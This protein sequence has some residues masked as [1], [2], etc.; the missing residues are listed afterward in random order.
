MDTSTSKQVE[1]ADFKAK[2]S[3][4]SWLYGH[5][6]G[7]FEKRDGEIT[8]VKGII[9]STQ[10]TDQAPTLSHQEFYQSSLQYA[11]LEFDHS[12]DD[13]DHLNPEKGQPNEVPIKDNGKDKYVYQT[14]LTDIILRYYTIDIIKTSGDIAHGHIKGLI[15]AK[16]CPAKK[17]NRLL[18]FLLLLLS[19][20]LLLL[21]VFKPLSP[22]QPPQP[23][24]WRRIFSPT[25]SSPSMPTADNSDESS[26]TGSKDG[27]NGHGGS[28]IGHGGPVFIPF[29]DIP[30]SLR[31]DFSVCQQSIRINADILFAF[32]SATLKPEAY[33]EI[34]QLKSFFD[35]IKRHRLQILITGHTDSY[36]DYDYNQRLSQRRA[37]EISH[38][39]I[40]ENWLEAEQIITEGRGENELIVSGHLNKQVQA[41]NRRVEISLVCDIEG[42]PI[43]FIDYHSRYIET[44]SKKNSDQ[45]IR[46][47]AIRIDEALARPEL[48]FNSCGKPLLISSDLVFDFD[49][50]T[51]KVNAI[52]ELKQI[53]NLLEKSTD[54]N[55]ILKVIGHTDSNGN[56]QHNQRLSERRAMRVAKWL[57]QNTSLTKEHLQIE[58][59]GE[60]QLLT[61]STASVEEQRINRRVEILVVCAQDT[62]KLK[63]DEKAGQ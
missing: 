57:I 6:E 28:G 51:L 2:G 35:V 46:P 47:K 22:T 18:P 60:T 29:R 19:I 52:T 20:L 33:E 23:F 15:W 63:I 5:F 11:W 53:A 39:L 44:P 61:S 13:T 36:G 16:A 1:Q 9:R 14:P 32:D 50:A 37:E 30:K 38:W 41:P 27:K 31:G 10:F 43:M 54:P 26:T 45:T 7:H 49:R 4:K 21:S 12:L 62:S 40:K 3:T 59:K 55:L 17:P 24:D 25:A 56:T 48:F 8:I 34:E 42:T 58:G